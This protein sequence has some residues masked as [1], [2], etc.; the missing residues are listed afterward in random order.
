MEDRGA[1]VSLQVYMKFREI[2]KACICTGSKFRFLNVGLALPRVD[3]GPCCLSL[4]T[5]IDPL[6]CLCSLRRVCFKC[7]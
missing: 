4:K 3:G 2:L 6:P 5:N 1:V 7:S